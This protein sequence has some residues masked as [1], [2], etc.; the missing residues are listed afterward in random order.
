MNQAEIKIFLESFKPKQGRTIVI[1]D[2]G[3]V[4]KWKNSLRWRVGVRELARLVKHFS[5]CHKFLRRFYYGADYGSNENSLLLSGW[6]NYI[7]TTADANG[8]EVIRKRVKYIQP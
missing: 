3:N 1:V 2:Y 6:S 5:Q 7:L 4:E 8:F